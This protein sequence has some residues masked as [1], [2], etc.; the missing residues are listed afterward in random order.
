MACC[1]KGIRNLVDQTEP[2]A[3]IGKVVSFWEVKDGFNANLI[4]CYL[5]ACK[6]NSV[7]S[8]D[9][10]CRVKYDVNPSTVVQP[11]DCLE[12]DALYGIGP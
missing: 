6:V 12:E 9:E 4:W 1:G 2:E 10:F 11:I 5:K 7:L 8:E 3:H